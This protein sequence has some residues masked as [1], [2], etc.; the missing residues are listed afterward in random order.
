MVGIDERLEG[1]KMCL[2]PSMNK[3]KALDKSEAQ[4]E[5]ARWFDKP[6]TSYLNRCVLIAQ[7]RTPVV[8]EVL[9]VVGNDPGRP[10]GR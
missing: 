8:T 6:G 7:V 2:R 1:I 3:F 9:Q 10:W 4:I 5:I